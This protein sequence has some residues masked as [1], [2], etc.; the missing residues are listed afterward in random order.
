MSLLENGL[1]ICSCKRKKCERF[2]DCTA[3]ISHHK[4]H[5]RYPLPYCKRHADKPVKRNKGQEKL[6][7]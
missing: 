7:L 3:C 4:T 5:K 6:P 1:E 2:G